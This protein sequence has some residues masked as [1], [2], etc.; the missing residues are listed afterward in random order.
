MC[1]RLHC[2]ASR[3]SSRQGV[4]I[5]AR[6]MPTRLCWRVVMVTS[7]QCLHRIRMGGTNKAIG[8]ET[9]CAEQFQVDERGTPFANLL[10][11]QLADH[12]AQL[13]TVTAEAGGDEQP[14]VAVHRA[15]N[16]LQVWRAVVHAREATAQ[17]G[18]VLVGKARMETG[19][20]H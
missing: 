3:S 10:R 6:F 18:S 1:W 12:R 20:E 19:G 4:S 16:G 8:L 5:S 7:A 9:R 11:H 17:R 13:E 14:I 15:Q 2:M